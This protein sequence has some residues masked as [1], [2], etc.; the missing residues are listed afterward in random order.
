MSYSNFF[1]FH[2]ETNRKP[3]QVVSGEEERS[4]ENA[5]VAPKRIDKSWIYPLITSGVTA[6]ESNR[7]RQ[8]CGYFESI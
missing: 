7:F 2:T 5:N 4:L 6:R 3:E 8:V 1:N